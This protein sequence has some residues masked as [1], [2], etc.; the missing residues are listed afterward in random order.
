MSEFEVGDW[1]T[2]ETPDGPVCGMVMSKADKPD[3]TIE[4]TLHQFPDKLDGI[5]LLNRALR[6]AAAMLTTPEAEFL[7]RWNCAAFGIDP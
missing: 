6:A 5:A 3:G 2:C 7:H 4:Y 1:A